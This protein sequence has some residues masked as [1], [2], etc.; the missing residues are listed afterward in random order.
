[1]EKIIE[2]YIFYINRALQLQYLIIHLFNVEFVRSLFSY[3]STKKVFS[4]TRYL[5]KVEL[6]KHFVIC[7]IARL[8]SIEVF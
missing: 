5:G 7:F 1:M 2:L 3:F 4:P 8:G 6:K